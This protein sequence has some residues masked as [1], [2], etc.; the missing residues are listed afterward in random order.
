MSIKIIIG[1][2][3]VKLS[4]LK[5]SGVLTFI[6]PDDIKLADSCM[7]EKIFS[8]YK[9]ECETES[10]RKLLLKTIKIVECGLDDIEP[11]NEKILDKRVLKLKSKINKL[12]FALQTPKDS[13]ID[14]NLEQK[15]FNRLK[16]FYNKHPITSRILLFL[17]TTIATVYITLFINDLYGDKDEVPC[18]CPNDINIIYNEYSIN[19]S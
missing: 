1:T 18:N 12:A 3:D 2:D 4:K 9:S 11:S 5:Y 19:Y 10:I 16:E 14:L 8:D 6:L 13:E 15:T 17:L 7:I